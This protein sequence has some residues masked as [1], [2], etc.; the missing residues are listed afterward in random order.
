MAL[1]LG[2]I[3]SVLKEEGLRDPTFPNAGYVIGLL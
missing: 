2:F 1:I 3:W